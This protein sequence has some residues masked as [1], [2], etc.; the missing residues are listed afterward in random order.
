MRVDVKMW[1]EL[2]PL[3]FLCLPEVKFSLA[4]LFLAANIRSLAAVGLR[5]T[6]PSLH[7]LLPHLPLLTLLAVKSDHMG[8]IAVNGASR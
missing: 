4:K 1:L 6:T 8:G 3:F 5:G 2:A 7:P